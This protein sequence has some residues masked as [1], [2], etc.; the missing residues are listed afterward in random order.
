MPAQVKRGRVIFR[1]WDK[2]SG[3]DETVTSFSTLEDLFGLCLQTNDPLLVDRVVIE[4][5]DEQ[6]MPHVV[7]LVFQ[8]LTLS[9]SG[10]SD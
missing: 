1:R 7:T 5:E 8:S 4:G 3:L 6:G 2:H 9:D 10:K